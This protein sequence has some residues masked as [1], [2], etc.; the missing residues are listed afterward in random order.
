LTNPGYVAQ[1]S[2]FY[3]QLA[4]C[5]GL[6]PADCSPAAFGL[7]NGPIGAIGTLP[8]VS[9]KNDRSAS[10]GSREQLRFVAGLKG[11]LPFME[12]GTLTNWSFDSYIS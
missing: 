10:D 12:M 5:Y 4:N 6:S 11:D 1:F 9:V 3:T 2:D 8:I 7:L